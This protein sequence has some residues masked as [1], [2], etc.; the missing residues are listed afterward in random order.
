MKDNRG[1]ATCIILPLKVQIFFVIFGWF[2]RWFSRIKGVIG[3]R[4]VFAGAPITLDEEAQCTKNKIL[5]NI[6]EANAW[7]ESGTQSCLKVNEQNKKMQTKG[8]LSHICVR[9]HKLDLWVKYKIENTKCTKMPKVLLHRKSS[10]LKTH[11]SFS[12]QAPLANT[13]KSKHCENIE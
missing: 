9:C 8:S 7:I 4:Q 11:K 6:D 12:A 5:Q 3:C 2:V 1:R 13:C 10:S